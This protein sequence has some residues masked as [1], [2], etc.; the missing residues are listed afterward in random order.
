MD[1]V[2]VEMEETGKVLEDEVMGGEEGAEKEQ[3]DVTEVEEKQDEPSVLVNDDVKSPNE[4][5]VEQEE[6]K[7]EEKPEELNMEDAKEMHTNKI[8]QELPVNETQENEK[9]AT[10]TG[11]DKIDDAGNNA[12][13]NGEDDTLD[14]HKNEVKEIGEDCKI[15]D[16]KNDD[17]AEIRDVDKIDDSNDGVTEI[18]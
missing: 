14:D 18:G 12:T 1:Q 11:D 5:G 9:D 2:D 4:I 6:Q 15:G 13:E 16:S 7:V 10:V 8:E 3:I 17:A